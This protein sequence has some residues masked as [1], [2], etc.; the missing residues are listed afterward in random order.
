MSRFLIILAVLLAS[1]A[2]PAASQ[3]KINP[4]GRR[5]L[6]T[7]IADSRAGVST[8]GGLELNSRIVVIT[9]LAKGTDPYSLEADDPELRVL[10]TRANMALIELP[11]GHVDNLALRP[12][13]KAVSFGN[14]AEP[15]L[16][17][18]RPASQ[19]N[20]LING[21]SDELL[22]NK[23]Y[24]GKGVIV[25][26]MDTGFD[27]NHINFIA[28]DGS[29]RVERIWLMSGGSENKATY[30][31]YASP[32]AIANFTTDS[33]SG[34]HATHVAGIAAGGYNG[35]GRVAVEQSGS[36][37]CLIY[38]DRKVPYYGIASQA[39]LAV[40]CGTLYNECILL[41]AEKVIEYAKAQG[42]PAVFNLSLGSTMG[43]HDGSDLFSQYLA[44]L[45][46][47]MVICIAAGND[48]D[49]GVSL[50]H[51]FSSSAPKLQT[52]VP[53]TDTGVVE[54][55][56]N[57]ST[58]FNVAFAIYN[59]NTNTIVMQQSIPSGDDEMV[60]TSQQNADN[61]YTYDATFAK[62]F[63]SS[64]VYISCGVDETNNRYNT[65][66]YYNLTANNQSNLVPGLI[67]TGPD[68]V[69]INSWIFTDP[70]ESFTSRGISGWTD[71][72]PSQS[73]NGMA[74]GDNIIVVGSYV[75]RNQWPTLSGYVYAYSSAATLVDHVSEF[76]S[77]GTTFAGR[78]LPDFCAPGQGIVSS[79]STYYAADLD[80]SEL[81][82]MSASAVSTVNNKERTNYWQVS[83]GTSMSTPY[84]TGV[85][86]QLLEAAGT[87]LTVDRVKEVMTAHMMPHVS[88]DAKESQQ[89][90]GGRI[91]AYE[92]MLALLGKPSAIANVGADADRRLLVDVLPGSL[93]VALPGEKSL[94]VTL[95]T[96]AGAAVKTV[97]TSGQEIELATE[98]LAPGIYIVSARG[99]SGQQA[100]KTISIN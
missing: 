67:Y 3:S 83:Q 71:G 9:S 20:L 93:R 24:R 98:S 58:A 86:A 13:V 65:Y 8:P 43:P 34:T 56:G 48:G 16:N 72:N 6:Q 68:G 96:V 51:T 70:S 75:S 99:A 53:I 19:A 92:A 95:L 49:L 90:G 78:A 10:A 28:S 57:N 35:T 7:A 52:F 69:E 15:Y 59:T 62:A 94:T 46:K 82:T 84:V 85:V 41:A 80:N 26:M 91:S 23:N 45:G 100:T 63:T 42:K 25:G 14:K 4:A 77:Y 47:D 74:C 37:T 39:S 73:I 31:E 89:W 38:D 55:W 17:K 50:Q 76:S 30:S 33:K 32:T 40:G 21:S 1:V 12:A 27:P 60:L 36:G 11:L 66:I 5:I 81:G 87:Q 64:Q 79:I 54:T 18:A 61:G 88:T 2:Q 97:S 22:N 29:N 44:E